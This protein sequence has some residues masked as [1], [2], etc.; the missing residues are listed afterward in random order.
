MEVAEEEDEGEEARDR[1]TKAAAERRKRIMAAMA[2]Q[3]NP[4]MTENT[5]LFEETP[6]DL[7]REHKQSVCEWELEEDDASP[8]CLGPARSAPAPLATHYTCILC[9]EE[10]QLSCGAN[11]LVM[12]SYVQR[13]TVLARRRPAAASRPADP[14]TFPFLPSDL[15]AAPHTS[16]C[17]H[18]MHAVVEECDAMET[19]EELAASPEPSQPLL[20]HQA[21][22]DRPE[23]VEAAAAHQAGAGGQARHARRPGADG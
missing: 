19:T 5:T 15:A 18:V 13:S 23:V 8:V 14:S 4:F 22:A 9:Q 10:E 16:S 1:R 21:E 2:N 17:S 11:T 12:A 3:Q 7:A 6:S 20:L